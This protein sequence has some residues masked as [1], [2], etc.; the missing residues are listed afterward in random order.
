[1]SSSLA[2]LTSFLPSI[3]LPSLPSLSSLP[4]IPIPQNLQNKLLSFLLQKSLGKY[5][6]TTDGKEGGLDSKIIETDLSKGEVK[7][8]G[9]ELSKEVCLFLSSLSL[10][11]GS[12]SSF[13]F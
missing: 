13:L 2:F 11:V 3:S 4:Q 5:L 6:K 7:I 8:L 1:M 9:L 10:P 12:Y